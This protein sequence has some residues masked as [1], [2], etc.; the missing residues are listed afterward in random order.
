MSADDGRVYWRQPRWLS[1]ALEE[2]EINRCEFTL[3]A[4]LGGAG[5]DRFGVDHPRGV[6]EPARVHDE[7][8]FHS[9]RRLRRKGS[10]SS[11]WANGNGG[12]SASPRSCSPGGNGLPHRVPQ[13]N[14][15][16]YWDREGCRH[17]GLPQ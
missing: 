10:S 11:T 13:S 1:R 14:P 4:Y 5:L 8:D 2:G 12:R 17:T 6:V 7:V 9:L 15:R 16:G 3:L